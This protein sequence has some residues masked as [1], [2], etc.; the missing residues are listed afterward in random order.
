MKRETRLE[1]FLR[2]WAQCNP[3]WQPIQVAMTEADEAASV[4]LAVIYEL[5]G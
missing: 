4:T 2:E 1:I 5:T 3:H